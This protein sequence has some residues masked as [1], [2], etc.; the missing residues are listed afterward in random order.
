NPDGSG[1]TNVSNNSLSDVEPNWAPDGTKLVWGREQSFADNT[2]IGDIFT[3]NANG[4]GQTNLT[5]AVPGSNI[6]NFQGSWQPVGAAALSIPLPSPA[7]NDPPGPPL[8]GPIFLSYK[9]GALGDTPR[10]V[11]VG[12][13]VTFTVQLS[14]ASIVPVQV[15]FTTINTGF[16]F[17]IGQ[18]AAFGGLDYT[19]HNGILT[20]QPGETSKQIHVNTLTFGGTTFSPDKIFGLLL[21]SPSGAI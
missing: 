18:Q 7:S 3:A 13:S 10:E 16:G 17:S 19:I 5:H 1:K 21:L 2:R 6:S 4:S 12:Q 8:F 20:F 9:S 11:V 14:Q 15:G